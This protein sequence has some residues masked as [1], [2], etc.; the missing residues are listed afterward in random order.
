MSHTHP[1]PWLHH[2][3]KHKLRFSK[4]ITRLWIYLFDKG[5]K[6]NRADHTSI[7]S[8]VNLTLIFWLHLS[9]STS[10]VSLSVSLF[11][12][13]FLSF[14]FCAEA[15]M[16]GWHD[17]TLKSSYELRFFFL[18]FLSVSM[19]FSP[20]RFIPSLRT[21]FC[22]PQIIHPLHEVLVD[23]TGN[24]LQQLPL[25]PTSVWRAL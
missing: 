15:D 21:A 17:A 12:N 22:C 23:L 16:H 4:V 7:Q 1:F 2:E 9:S 5:G 25:S 11:F 10:S 8:T 20:S 3:I 19:S 18:F 14:D 13:I 24:M 6:L